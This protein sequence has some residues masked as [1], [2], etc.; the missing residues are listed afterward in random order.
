[1]YA[2]DYFYL[3]EADS[4][5]ELNDRMDEVAR[6]VYDDCKILL[7]VTPADK[8]T[9]LSKNTP[10]IN[11]KK[12]TDKAVFDAL[13]L[14]C[15]QRI[16]EISHMQELGVDSTEEDFSKVASL[17]SS[18]CRLELMKYGY[19]KASFSEL[20]S[21]LIVKLDNDDQEAVSRHQTEE[22]RF[23]EDT[24]PDSALIKFYARKLL[25]PAA[26]K[27]K[28]AMQQKVGQAVQFN[29]DPNARDA[30]EEED[31]FTR[32]AGV[33]AQLKRLPEGKRDAV[34]ANL[35]RL[36]DINGLV[37][38]SLKTGEPVQKVVAREAIKK[39][40]DRERP[41][42][43]ADATATSYTARVYSMFFDSVDVETVDDRKKS[44]GEVQEQRQQ[45]RWGRMKSGWADGLE[46]A[47]AFFAGAAVEDDDLVKITI[48]YI[49]IT[50]PAV[51][52]QCIDDGG[53]VSQ[54]L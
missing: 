11:T 53:I 22:A 28:Q 4:A 32:A 27:L 39:A 1:M 21:A 44:Q 54:I 36:Y 25:Q 47:G 2:D 24:M 19:Q 7:G 8:N 5:T 34:R 16:A 50:A 17:A 23:V 15:E 33:Q 40:V 46:A 13:A 48:R 31:D 9:A 42:S 35:A 30:A 43:D 6:A 10:K 52:V 20:Y 45:T 37:N 51:I 12:V 41:V 18:L 38:N 26:D 49:T 14:Y 3:H 29:N